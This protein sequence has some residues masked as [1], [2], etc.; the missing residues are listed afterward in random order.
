MSARASGYGTVNLDVTAIEMDVV[1]THGKATTL[2]KAM[3][4]VATVALCVVAIAALSTSGSVDPTHMDEVVDANRD[5][6]RLAAVPGVMEKAAEVSNMTAFG[7]RWA[8][9]GFDNERNKILPTMQGRA[10]DDWEKDFLAFKNALPNDDVAAAIYNFEFWS[11]EESKENMPILVSWRPESLEPREEARAGYYLGSLMVATDD[12]V[13]QHY[14]MDSMNENYFEFCSKTMEIPIKQCSLDKDFHNCPFGHTGEDGAVAEL[15]EDNPCRDDRCQGAT[16]QDPDT[17]LDGAIPQ[18]CCTYILDVY[19]RDPMNI[20]NH[21]CHPTVLSTME[22]ECEIPI[23]HEVPELL[24]TPEDEQLCL[25]ECIQ[26]CS[27]FEDPNDTWRKCSGCA[28]DG[29]LHDMLLE[30]G[31][32]ASEERAYQCHSDAI[33]FVMQRCCGIAPE[34]ATESSQTDFM[35]AALEYYECEWVEHRDCP[36]LKV[37]QTRA[38]SPAGCCESRSKADPPLETQF[39]D[40]IHEVDCGGQYTSD[41]TIAEWDLMFQVDRPCADIQEEY[42]IAEEARL[43]AIADALAAAEAEAEEEPAPARRMTE[44]DYAGTRQQRRNAYAAMYS[45]KR[46]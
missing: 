25:D 27:L 38:A 43:Q 6:M 10:T 26:P 19:C 23:I 3:A 36:E 30:A 8:I 45:D 1:S 13:V 22:K 32:D 7:L 42:R 16:F 31:Q 4:A 29:Q 28:V 35:C 24:V 33:G 41:E 11:D 46:R 18:A 39:E 44:S 15:Q 21:G 14:P 12:Y 34:C 5:R 17:V 20:D 37:M 2:H 40:D 9:F